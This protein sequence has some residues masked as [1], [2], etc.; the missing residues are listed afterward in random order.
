MRI[1]AVQTGLSPLSVLGGTVTDREFLTRL[2]DR[3]VE[4]HIMAEA[5]EPVVGHPNFVHHFWHR[6]LKKRLPYIGNT[7]VALDLRQLLKR[8]GHVDWIRFNS[9]YSVGIGT[10]LSKAGH[11]VWASY[12][13]C[14]H[15]RFWRWVD[16]WLPKH[17]DLITCISDDTRAD[18]VARC[19]QANHG[20]TVVVPIGI[21][22][23]RFE[24]IPRSRQAVRQ[25]LGIADSELLMLY[26][27]SLIPRKGIAD[28]VKT[29]ELLGPRS[30]I[31]LLVIGRSQELLESRLIADLAARDRRVIHIE[32]VLYERTPEYFQASDIFL[33][34][35]HLEGFGIVVGEAMASG[36]PVVTTRAKG[37]RDVV[38]EHETAL[39]ADVGCP[40]QLV[41]HLERLVG[42]AALRQKL[43][44]MGRA[45]VQNVFNWDRSI[46]TLLGQLQR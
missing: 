19:P 20:R 26:V 22:T 43:G 44:T 46:D 24:Q 45:R 3:G 27:G 11:P 32:K 28:L 29:W 36:L 41:G 9:P 37:V 16:S 40:E 13:H 6:R 14:E 7:D 42:D 39:L 2:A 18:L 34:P 1:V 38:V 25:E 31:R 17:C 10:L 8:L 23:R 21:D 12:L 30:D 4:V 5:G 33:F 35:T 15:N